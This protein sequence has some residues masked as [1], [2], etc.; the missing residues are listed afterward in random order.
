MFDRTLRY[1]LADRDY[2]QWGHYLDDQLAQERCN[3]AW[4]AFRL[5]QQGIIDRDEVLTVVSPRELHE[6]ESTS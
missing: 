3:L 4:K 5:F 6:M 1:A 2:R